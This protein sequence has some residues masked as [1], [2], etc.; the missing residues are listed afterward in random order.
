MKIKELYK[1]SPFGTLAMLCV[2][3]IYSA[4][5]TLSS[6][7]TKDELI[8]LGKVSILLILITLAGAYFSVHLNISQT[9]WIEEK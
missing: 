6:V 8:Y 2:G 3:F 1:A 5:L 9:K 4:I 7:Y